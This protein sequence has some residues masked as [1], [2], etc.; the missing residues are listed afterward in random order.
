MNYFGAA[1]LIYLLVGYQ[2][3]EKI[4]KQFLTVVLLDIFVQGNNSVS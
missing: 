4:S 2:N 3:L 1:A